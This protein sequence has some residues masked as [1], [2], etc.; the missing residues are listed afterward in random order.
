MSDISSSSRT[1][2]RHRITSSPTHPSTETLTVPIDRPRPP[3]Y[4]AFPGSETNT[5]SASPA[6]R[7][8]S[9]GIIRGAIIGTS[10]IMVLGTFTAWRIRRR[11]RQPARPPPPPSISRFSDGS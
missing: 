11:K 8:Q 9:S 5:G 1:S 4:T 2:S 3:R 7:G 6:E 10:A